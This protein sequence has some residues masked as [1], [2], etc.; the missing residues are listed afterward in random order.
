MQPVHLLL[1]VVVLPLAVTL[2]ALSGPPDPEPSPD[3]S[4]AEVVR[5]QVEALGANDD[6][7][8]DAGVRTAF[9]FTSP[10]NRAATGPLPRFAAMVHGPVYADM[11]DFARAEFGAVAV[12]GDRAAQRVTVFHHD[13]RRAVF[14]FGLSRRPD[15]GCAGCWMTDAVE[16]RELSEAAPTRI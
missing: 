14:V 7:E 1:A 10:S 2:A 12:D 3:L 5:I 15:G 16:R 11:L 6:P 13:G 8:P 4:P 9:R